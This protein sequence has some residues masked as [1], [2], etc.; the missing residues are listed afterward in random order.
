MRPRGAA[1][2]LSVWARAAAP[3]QEALLRSLTAALRE[4]LD[5]DAALLDAWRS[6][7]RLGISVTVRIELGRGG[8][9]PQEAFE[10]CTSDVPEW[11][12]AD[13][14]LLR[15]TGI[16][17]ELVTERRIRATKPRRRQPR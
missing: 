10:R 8:E 15:S 9:A 5:P 7:Q 11:S 3:A 14:E 1:V 16:A 4:R 6:L 2:C 12:A 13:G 17:N